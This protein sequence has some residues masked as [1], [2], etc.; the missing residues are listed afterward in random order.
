M[1]S[2]RVLKDQGR[3]QYEH[4]K[5]E[6]A[7]GLYQQAYNAAGAVVTDALDRQVLLSNIVACRLKLGQNERA[8]Q[9]AQE[10][11]RLNPSWSKAHVRLAST[12]IALGHSNDACNALQTALRHDPSN[13]AARQMLLQQLQN[14]DRRPTTTTPPQQPQP[15][16]DIDHRGTE[17][18]ASS[19]GGST[20][21]T[22]NQR[23]DTGPQSATTR[24]DEDVD[25]TMS[26]R[27]RM[28]ANWGRMKHW[29]TS[30]SDTRKTGIKVLIG[31]MALYMS[32]GGR[33]GLTGIGPTTTTDPYDRAADST[34]KTRHDYGATR[35]RRVEDDGSYHRQRQRQQDYFEPPRSSSSSYR[36]APLQGTDSSYGRGYD[37]SNDYYRSRNNYRSSF[38]TNYHGRSGISSYGSYAPS[39]QIMFMV[40]TI[41]YIC[42]INGI[43]IAPLFLPGGV[44]ILYGGGFRG[45]PHYY[46]R[47]GGW[48]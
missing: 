11:I 44:G 43:N 26:A 15:N 47:R 40:L 34:Y 24:L 28:Q 30:Q 23:P 41:A 8:L 7:L 31:I 36:N 1:V 2:W 9:D 6:E 46:R 39:W 38:T 5:F 4:G 16:P 35:N 20:G 19:R 45:R 13:T 37:T 18:E 17:E 21:N 22:S 33:F 14:R 10:C 32:F 42:R 27:D 48:W 3:V 12:Y 29:Y 25:D